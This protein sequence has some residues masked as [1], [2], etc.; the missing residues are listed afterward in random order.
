MKKINKNAIL[1]LLGGF[2]IFLLGVGIG[3]SIPLS[4]VSYK[5]IKEQV[6]KDL[7]Q[8]LNS[9]AEKRLIPF[10]LSDASQKKEQTE[11]SL[12]GEIVKVDS[13]N[14]I[15]KI[16]V[17]NKYRSGNL[18][19]YLE[20]PDYYV[21]TVIINKQTRIFKKERKS[22][23]DFRREMQEYR[24]YMEKRREGEL[25]EGDRLISPKS[26]IEI[27]VAIQDLKNGA[28]VFVESE[29]EFKLSEDKEVSAKKIE[30]I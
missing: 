30:I 25:P 15:I 9:K 11:N 28:K 26:F 6:V 12:T 23:E 20:E 8:K 10:N 17:E 13:Q 18:F 21:K 1:I 24:E 4:E 27:E 5:N 7:E 2:F 19:S 29:I 14:N 3:K 22:S 16:K